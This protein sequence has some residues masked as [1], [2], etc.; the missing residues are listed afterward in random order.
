MYYIDFDNTLYETGRLT[1][2][3]LSTF[4]K[5]IGKTQG[6]NPNIVLEELKKSF[7][8]TVDN[9][10]SFATNLSEKYNV[11]EHTLQSHLK[12]ILIENGDK[13]TFPD[14]IE[15]LKRLRKKGE[16]ICILTYVAQK[17]NLKQQALKLAGSGIL[18][19]I[20][21]V[22]NTTRFKYELAIDYKNGIFIDDSPRDLEGLYKAGVRHLIRIKKPNNLKRTS[23]ELNIPEE[24][25]TYTSFDEIEI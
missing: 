6:I 5:V 18:P 15:F 12:K 8:S 10:E 14:A 17:K 16:N 7:N 25:P 22:Y 2:E 19:Y 13:F 21:E 24:I 20:D 9:F 1:K 23:K 4:A 11:N 3:V